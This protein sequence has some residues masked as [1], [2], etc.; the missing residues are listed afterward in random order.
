MRMYIDIFYIYIGKV[1][2]IYKIK[3][4]NIVYIESKKGH[5]IKSHIIIYRSNINFIKL[6]Y[7]KKHTVI[8]IYDI[9]YVYVCEL[10]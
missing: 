6:L 7:R 2:K 8:Q 10:L 3:F 4:Y 1:D 9:F 5:K